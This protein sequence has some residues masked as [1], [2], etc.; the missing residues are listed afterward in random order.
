MSDYI[1]NFCIDAET[2]LKCKNPTFLEF[3]DETGVIITLL[4]YF[5]RYLPQVMASKLD[6]HKRNIKID[7]N[8][9]GVVPQSNSGDYVIV[10]VPSDDNSSYKDDRFFFE[11]SEYV[12][13]IQ[14]E[15]RDDSS[16]GA[17]QNLIA[18]KSGIKTM[19]VNMET[20]LGLSINIEGFSFEGPYSI[21]GSKK[22]IR[23]GTYRFSVF[24]SK[25]K[26]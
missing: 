9:I 11:D 25:Q 24:E 19:L 4:A 6:C 2:V 22:L 20:N 8:D 15:T 3:E 21:E 7:P 23:Q 13:Q 18:L 17:L 10:I 14:I 12:F 26:K 1:S 5:K 16:E